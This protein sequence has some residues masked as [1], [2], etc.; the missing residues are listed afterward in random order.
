MYDEKNVVRTII[1]NIP[2]LYPENKSVIEF[3]KLPES[4]TIDGDWEFQGDAVVRI[5]P[6]YEE[7][8]AIAEKNRRSLLEEAERK[9]APLRDAVSLEIAT[10]EG[11]LAYDDWRK[12]RFF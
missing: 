3:D 2:G 6:S 7:K 1:K 8:I 5:E 11:I 10:D 9:N 4:V 12:Y